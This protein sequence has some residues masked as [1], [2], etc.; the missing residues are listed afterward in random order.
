MRDGKRCRP[1]GRNPRLE[2][3]KGGD[4][5]IVCFSVSK[6]HPAKSFL[7]RINGVGVYF[8]PRPTA[9]ICGGTPAGTVLT[10]RYGNS[11]V[12][13]VT[14]RVS[15]VLCSIDVDARTTIYSSVHRSRNT[16][17]SI[18]SLSPLSTGGC[19]CSTTNPPH[20]APPPSEP[21]RAGETRTC[22]KT[23]ESRRPPPTPPSTRQERCPCAAP[24]EIDC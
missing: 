2:G 23:S 14:V 15:A 13:R 20:R 18:G 7:T 24:W 4:L 1:A 12:L 8:L 11:G 17:V 3:P 19:A 10:P 6:S 16:C 9:S 21:W 22:P 5:L